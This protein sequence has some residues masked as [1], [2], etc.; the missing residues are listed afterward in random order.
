MHDPV[1]EQLRLRTALRRLPAWPAPA[2]GWERVAAALQ[3]PAVP[4][5]ARRAAPSRL[6]LAASVLFGGT[7]TLWLAT[8]AGPG[9]TVTQPESAAEAELQ[10]L[11]AQSQQLEAILHDLPARP[12]VERAMTAVTIS[13]L[14]DRIQLLD[15]QLAAAPD[16]GL[17]AERVQLMNSLVGVRYAESLRAGYRPNSYP[18]EM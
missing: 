11:V 2:G 16:A 1:D 18:G 5:P 14:Q 4:A 6:A 15:S 9:T 12:A 13:A 17:W 7:L 3:P 8:G 10:R